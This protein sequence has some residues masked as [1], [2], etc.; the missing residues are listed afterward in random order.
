[1]YQSQVTFVMD[2]ICPWTYLG[3]KRFDEAL[4]QF[5]SSFSSSS[6][7]FTLQFASYQPNP[8]R[9]ETTPD[10][11][12]YAL[13]KK[14]NGNKEAQKL[15]EEHMFSLAKP[16]NIP[17]AFTGPTGNSF[18]A[19]RVIQ[20]VQESCGA[21]VTNKLVDAVFKL[22]FAEGRHPGSDDMLIEAC[23]E[24]GVDEKEA[25]ALIEDKARGERETKE[26]IRRI[27]ADIDAVPTVIIEGRRR[28]LTLTGLKEVS[29]YIKA[30]ETIAKESS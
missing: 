14:H 23:S 3:K 27:G 5:G 18:P 16:L 1:M 17:I 9:P 11:A 22:Y 24:A 10:R 19:H 7:S 6:I 28:D 29:E 13:H 20:Q 30:M 15:F 26:E 4:T 2:T 12:T 25:K 8:K 21:D